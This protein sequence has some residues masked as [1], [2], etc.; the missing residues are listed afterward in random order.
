MPV[1]NLSR[2]MTSTIKYFTCLEKFKRLW[3]INCCLFE[4]L[5]QISLTSKG[6]NEA[7]KCQPYRVLAIIKLIVKLI[8]CLISI[9]ILRLFKWRWV[10]GTA[11]CYSC[12][13][14]LGIMLQFDLFP[15]IR[16]LILISL[17]FGY[18]ESQFKCYSGK[19]QL[20]NNI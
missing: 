18:G 13:K 10:W 17:F 20:Y 8:N 19:F 5:Q 14:T 1:L 11:N 15:K 6:M 16:L 9:V 4:K 7:I 3:N 2:P 12:L